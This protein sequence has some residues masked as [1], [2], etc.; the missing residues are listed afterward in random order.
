MTNRTKKRS[1]WLPV[2][3]GL[4]VVFALASL[5]RPGLRDEGVPEELVGH[6]K[7]A[8]DRYADRGFS[9]T[10]STL[11][12][13]TSASDSTVHRI[14]SATREERAGN[15]VYTILYEDQGAVLPFA[16]AYGPRGPYGSPEWLHLPH[17]PEIEWRREGRP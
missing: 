16:V 17:Q 10:E 9:I 7:A 3:V 12:L 6:W 8:N 15:L 1:R 4:I 11:A 14:R 5:F 13:F 2:A